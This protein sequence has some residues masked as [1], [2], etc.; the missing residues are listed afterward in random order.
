MQH[1]SWPGVKLADEVCS[2]D[3]FIVSRQAP[4]SPD[5]RRDFRL[6]FNRLFLHHFTLIIIVDQYIVRYGSALLNLVSRIHYHYQ[7]YDDQHILTPVV[8]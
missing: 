8:Y 2:K 3:V 4:I 6:S 5:E 1:R 7:M